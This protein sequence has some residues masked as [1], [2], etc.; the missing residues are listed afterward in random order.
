MLQLDQGKMD[1]TDFDLHEIQY[2]QPDGSAPLLASV[3][4]PRGDGPFPAVIELHGGAWCLYDRMRDRPV[5]EALA[6]SGIVVVA[7]DFRMGSEGAYPLSMQDINYGV[8][9]VKANSERLLTRP[10]LVGIHGQSSGGHLAM[11][12][13]MRPA[14]PRYNALPLP[15]GSPDVDATVRCVTMMWPVINPIG[16]Y[17]HAKRLQA[18]ADPPG[19]TKS[20]IERHDKYWLTAENMAEGSPLVALQKGEEVFT[21]PALWIQPKDDPVHIYRDPMSAEPETDVEKFVAAYRKAGGMI[22]LEYFDAPEGF[23]NKNPN[24][25]QSKDAYRKLV[26]FVHKYILASE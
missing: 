5:H 7:L 4:Q 19:W 26:S 16:R 24:S 6:S 25:S 1:A 8:R 17:R 23:T 18:D 3:Y 11:L 14:D 21:P 13:A 10:D 2:R 22:D 20:N 9:W 12:H 15:A